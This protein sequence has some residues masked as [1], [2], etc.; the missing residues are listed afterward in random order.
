MDFT[1][2]GR[3]VLNWIHLAQDS[4]KCQTLVN[5]IVKVETPQQ[6]GNFM[7]G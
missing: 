4:N 5:T 2:V 6:T 7:I 3:Q 1:E